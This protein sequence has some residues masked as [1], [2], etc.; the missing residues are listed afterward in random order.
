MTP[1][2]IVSIVYCDLW[3]GTQQEL[4]KR[5][6]VPVRRLNSWIRQDGHYASPTQSD[7]DRTMRAAEQELAARLGRTQSMIANHAKPNESRL[8]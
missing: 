3:P 6:R 4:A 8:T 1:T 7:A 2:E 5:V